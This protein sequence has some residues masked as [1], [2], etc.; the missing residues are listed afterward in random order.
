M[1]NIYTRDIKRITMELYEKYKDEISTDFQQNKQIV[2]K[3]I[4]VYSKKIRNRIAGYL[5]RYARRMKNIKTE[6]TE[7]MVE[8]E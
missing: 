4:D 8:E 5:T 7:E 6:G 1:G 3:Y 2:A